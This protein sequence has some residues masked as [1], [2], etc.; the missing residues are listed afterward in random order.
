MDFL[1]IIFLNK[2]GEKRKIH[3]HPLIYVLDYIQK[4]IKHFD[5]SGV[6]LFIFNAILIAFVFIAF[7]LIIYS[8]IIDDN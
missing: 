7:F 6:F 1:E 8:N 3:D 4:K 2:N 5:T